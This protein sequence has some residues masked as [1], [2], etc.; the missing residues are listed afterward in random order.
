MYELVAH[1]ILP[2]L[3]GFAFASMFREHEM[4]QDELDSLQA[5]AIQDVMRQ[6]QEIAAATVSDD[7]VWVRNLLWHS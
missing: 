2:R 1:E 6:C 4:T 3:C 7:Q 5:Q